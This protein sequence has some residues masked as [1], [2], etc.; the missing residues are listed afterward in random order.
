MAR[1]TNEIRATK[2][3]NGEDVVMLLRLPTNEEVNDFLVQ[4]YEHRGGKK[5][6]D[7]SYQA[8]TEFFDL[9]LV[10]VE[11]LEDSEGVSVTPERKELIPAHWKAEIIFNCF[12]NNEID[13]KN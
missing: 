7:I 5:M 10:K 8:R 6:K 3:L 4:R 2:K 9:L 11:N 1:L 12:E 13:I